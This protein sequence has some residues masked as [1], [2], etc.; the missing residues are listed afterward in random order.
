[1]NWRVI[2]LGIVLIIF[3]M[4]IGPEGAAALLSGVGTWIADFIN[5][6]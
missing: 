3:L 2:G 5:A 4:I 6:L 1:M